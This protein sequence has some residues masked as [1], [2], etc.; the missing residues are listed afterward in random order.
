MKQL[1]LAEALQTFNNLFD[2]TEQEMFKAEVLQ[3]YS[4]V[5]D[6]PSLRAWFAGNKQEARELGKKDAN[7]IAY[8]NKCIKSPASIARVH[9]IDLH[10]TPYLEWEIAVCYKDS[11]LAYGAESIFLVQAHE[12]QD[13]NLPLG[14]FWIF[15]N[16]RVLQWEYDGSSGQT[17]GARL[18]DE[19]KGDRVDYFRQ[20]KR[21]LLSN[22]KPLE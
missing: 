9:I 18:W 16:T 8:R 15:D 5:D 12:L 7:I 1:S 4:A 22:A 11:L 14:D 13:I 20:L 6:S 19:S 21:I 2:A 17:T 3:D 10:L